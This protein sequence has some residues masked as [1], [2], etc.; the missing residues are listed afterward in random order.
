MDSARVNC[1][2][3]FNATFL[4]VMVC[5][6]L[7]NSFI[8][9]KKNEKWINVDPAFSKYVDAYTTGVISKTSN[10]RILL[11]A[12]AN[13]SHAVGEVVNESLFELSPAVK[14][15]TVWVDARTI[16]FKPQE[17]LKKDQQYTVKFKLGKVT[18]VP[19]KF[20]DFLLSI[21]TVKPSF[22]F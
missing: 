18:K 3:K 8:S 15:K 20:S 19:A 2:K 12:D 21:K 4:L 17:Q 7:V 11:A 1:T 10:L 13:T 5:I 9:C 16:E 6:L 14:G 22:K